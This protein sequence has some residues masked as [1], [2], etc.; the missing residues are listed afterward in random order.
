MP[1]NLVENDRPEIAD[2]S[3]ITAMSAAIGRRFGTM[4]RGAQ[5]GDPG[6]PSVRG[7]G[8]LLWH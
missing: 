3:D 5:R 8:K 6:R 7:C 4:K 1:K 2:Q